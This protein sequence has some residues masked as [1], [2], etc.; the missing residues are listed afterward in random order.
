MAVVTISRQCGSGGAEIAKLAS[1]MLSYKFLDKHMIGR[2][3]YNLG[4]SKDEIIEYP[5]EGKKH[6]FLDKLLRESQVLPIRNPTPGISDAMNDFESTYFVSEKTSEIRSVKLV[7]STIREIGKRGNVV[8]LGRG[9]Q[10]I[11]KR[12]SD[13]LHVR[14]VAPM[15]VRIQRIRE[16]ENFSTDKEAKTFI[17][18]SD[19]TASK[20]L[21]NTYG[22]DWEDP[23]L[24]HLVINTGKFG[25]ESTVKIIINGVE[26]ISKRNK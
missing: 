15:E 3:A 19:L 24:Y 8:I 11:L 26:V 25:V 12:E 10:A 17:N 14:I 7:E 23:L 2:V 22:I 9:G 1:K 4:L 16:D 6:V 20:Y 13:V 5:V 21:K 18:R